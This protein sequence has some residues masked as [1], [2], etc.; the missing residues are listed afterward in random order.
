MNFGMI[1]LN[2]S[3][4]TMQNYITWTQT[5]LLFIINLN[6]FIKIL[7]MILKKWSDTSNYSEEDK[8]PL[9]MLSKYK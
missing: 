8:R 5:A 1:L 7:Q 4:K 3:I 2:Q 9:Y 6:I